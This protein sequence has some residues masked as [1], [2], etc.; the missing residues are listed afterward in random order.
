MIEYAKVSLLG[1]SLW[2]ALFKKE[3]LK[4][5]EWSNEEELDE[6]QRYCYEK[7]SDMHADILAEVFPSENRNLKPVRK[8]KSISQFQ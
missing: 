7:Y 3:L 5:I 4:I 6:L 1:V 8:R 2:K